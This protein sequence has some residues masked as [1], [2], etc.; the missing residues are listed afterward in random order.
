MECPLAAIVKCGGCSHEWEPEGNVAGHCPECDQQMAQ[1]QRCPDCPGH[2]I[3]HFRQTTPAGRLL[4]RILELEFDTKNLS[5]DWAD[6]TAE[7]VLG[8]RILEQE[9]Q[10]YTNEQREEMQREMEEKRAIR[11]QQQ[12]R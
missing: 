9:R 10:K 4:N 3:D 7:E 12:R 11:E 1:T 2:Q 8:L 5:V 6:I